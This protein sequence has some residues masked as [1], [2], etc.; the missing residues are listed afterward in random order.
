VQCEDVS[1]AFSREASK[2]S[3]R[4]HV[5]RNMTDKWVGVGWNGVVSM[6][7]EVFL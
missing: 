4:G 5:L 6:N 2:V 7:C 3:W 1:V